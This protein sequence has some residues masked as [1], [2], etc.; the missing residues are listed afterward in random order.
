MSYTIRVRGAREFEQLARRLESAAATLQERLAAGVRDEGD[1][2]LGAVRAAWMGVEVTS[3][4][5][6]G[7][8][9]GLRARVAA[10]TTASPLPNGVRIEVDARAVDGAYGPTLVRGLNGQGRWR[11]PVFGNT[12]AWTQQTG[13]NVFE[14]TIRENEPRFE[15]GLQRVIDEV[16]REI[17][18]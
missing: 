4:G 3:T 13:Q 2:V 11:H 14:P 16:A 15:A 18:G 12:D 7:S 17:E 6:G 1:S 5:S 8:S 9:S 10:A